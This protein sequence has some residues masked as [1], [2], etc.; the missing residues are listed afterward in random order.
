MS[1]P[2]RR[3][4]K[5]EHRHYLQRHVSRRNRETWLARRARDQ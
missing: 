1:L 4:A 3:E 2:V 5:L